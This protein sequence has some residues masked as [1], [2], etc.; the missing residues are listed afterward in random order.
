[1]LNYCCIVSWQGTLVS[2]F[3]Y[4]ILDIAGLSIDH[5]EASSDKSYLN[6]KVFFINFVLIVLSRSILSTNLVQFCILLD[7]IFSVAMQILNI[8]VMS[9]T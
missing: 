1:M 8:F 7:F 3:L 6:Q 9:E 4:S 2:S 5:E